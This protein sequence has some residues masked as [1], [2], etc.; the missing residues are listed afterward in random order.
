M[1]ELHAEHW[2]GWEGAVEVHPIFGPEDGA[3]PAS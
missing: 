2:P 1:I 3:P